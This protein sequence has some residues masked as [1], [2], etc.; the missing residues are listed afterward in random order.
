[1]VKY[2]LEPGRVSTYLKART[3]RRLTDEVVR[4]KS[5]QRSRIKGGKKTKNKNSVT[6]GKQCILLNNVLY[7]VVFKK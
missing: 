5:R 6:G 4:A 3:Q 1:M 2:T 7:K